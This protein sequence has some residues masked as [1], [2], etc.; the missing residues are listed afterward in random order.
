MRTARLVL[1]LL[2]LALAPCLAGATATP[3]QKCAVAKSKAAS[4]K[5]AGKL[6]CWQKALLVGASTPDATCITAVETKYGL[7]VSKIDTKGGC[8][9]PGDGATLE[10]LVDGAVASLAAFTPATPA[11]CCT[12]GAGACWMDADPNCQ[13]YTLGGTGTACDGSG[14]C[15]AAP[16]TPGP[17][18]DDP[19][20]LAITVTCIGGPEVGGAG[21]CDTIY[22]GTPVANGLCPPNG[23]ACIAF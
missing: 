4:K 23:G 1:V 13:G 21:H 8:D 22:N 5:V 7:T 19:S 17:C 12:D 18:C 3:G 11:H 6:K 10:A 2:A 15:V 16:A 14:G 20:G 9:F